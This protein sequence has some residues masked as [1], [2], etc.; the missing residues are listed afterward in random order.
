VH[1]RWRSDSSTRQNRHLHPFPPFDEIGEVEMAFTLFGAEITGAEQPAETA[2]GGT[3]GRPD[4]DVGCA[5]AKRESAA[6][7]ITR[8]IGL[9]S[10]M[11]ADDAGERVAVGDRK[12][13]KAEFGRRLGKLF[14]V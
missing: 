13:G 11:A 4:R 6:D 10:E 7:D 8:A 3:I 14:R 9:R 12:A 5:I 2:I 1:T